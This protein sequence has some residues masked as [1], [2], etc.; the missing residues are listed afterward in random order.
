MW[1]H[2]TRTRGSCFAPISPGSRKWTPTRTAPVSQL[3]HDLNLEIPNGKG[4]VQGPAGRTTRS[5]LLMLRACHLYLYRDSR[6]P[7]LSFLLYYTVQCEPLRCYINH[8]FPLETQFSNHD[9]DT[10]CFIFELRR[11]YVYCLSQV[12]SWI[13]WLQ[14]QELHFRV[15]QVRQILKQSVIMSSYVDSFEV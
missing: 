8:P 14:L 9:L 3:L 5:A 1:L 2:L 13:L 15:H 11:L 12:P 10:D 7:L 4:T 6:S